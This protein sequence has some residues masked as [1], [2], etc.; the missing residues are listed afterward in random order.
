MEKEIWKDVS[1]FDNHYQISNLGRFKRKERKTKSAAKGHNGFR[2]L[3]E[4]I[5]YQCDN[6]K[7]Y[8]FVYVQINN[9]RIRAYVHRLVAKYFI[10]NPNNYAEVNHKDF[11][12][13]N[14]KA[15]NLEWCNRL[16]NS[17]HY[18]NS[19]KNKYLG[20]KRADSKRESWCAIIVYNNKYYHIGVYRTKEEARIA[21]NKF[22]DEHNFD[23]IKR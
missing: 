9:K 5:H 12:K 13:S 1:E 22:I 15:S 21:R 16:Y 14:N 23:C 18:S 7:G 3:K 17:T 20:I 6:G 8:K 11:N 19:I 2:V 4:K 10:E